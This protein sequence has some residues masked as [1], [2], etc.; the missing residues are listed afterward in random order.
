MYGVNLSEICGVAEIR[1]FSFWSLAAKR[2]SV[3]LRYSMCDEDTKG[4]YGVNWSE[5]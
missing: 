3:L 1:D 5:I 2:T 4:M